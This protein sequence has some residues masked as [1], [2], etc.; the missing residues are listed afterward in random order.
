[1]YERHFGFTA[2]P[3]ALTPDPSFLYLSP[4]HARALTM[5]EYG[6]ESESPFLLLTGDIG[7]GKTTMVQTLLRQL[8]DAERGHY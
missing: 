1:M 4:Q 3:F 2:K 7:A 5:L 8:G 6:L